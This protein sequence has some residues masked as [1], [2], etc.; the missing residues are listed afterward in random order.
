MT[1]KDAAQ[2]NDHD[3]GGKEQIFAFLVTA[4]ARDLQEYI[5]NI[6]VDTFSYR[7]QHARTAL[8]VRVSEDNLKAAADILR[9]AEITERLT[10]SL[11]RLTWGLLMLT[12]GLLVFEII[13]TFY[14]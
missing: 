14:H 9:S 5:H 3:P 7:Y 8:D 4:S 10:G 12:A 13:H 1:G 6:P 11:N 2:I